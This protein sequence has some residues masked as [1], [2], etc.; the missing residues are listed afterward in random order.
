MIYKHYALNPVA[1]ERDIPESNVPC[2][3]CIECCVG[4]TPYLTPSEFESGEYIYT[5]LSGPENKP[6][7][8]IP[9]TQE[10]CIYLKDKKCTIYEKRPLACRQFDCRLGH[11]PNFKE[12][13]ITKFNEY[14][15]SE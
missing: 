5:F 1:I 6:C 7:I 4:L 8:A 10:G 14:Q 9:R 11:H 3:D 13:A 2:G 12:I 15:E